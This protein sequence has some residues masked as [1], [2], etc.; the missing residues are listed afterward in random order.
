M[1]ETRE[2]S[3]TPGRSSFWPAKAAFVADAEVGAR[4]HRQLVIGDVTHI[5]GANPGEFALVELHDPINVG[6]AAQVEV[7]AELT[8]RLALAG[9]EGVLRAAH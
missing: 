9:K 1:F 4:S 5:L 7:L 6:G 2:L 3:S 8:Q